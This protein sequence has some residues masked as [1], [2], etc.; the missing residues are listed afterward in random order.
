MFFIFDQLSQMKLRTKKDWGT[1]VLEDLKY[2]GLSD[3]EQIRK[4]KKVSFMKLVRT[5]IKSDTFEKLEKIKSSHSKV[6]HL[7]HKSLKMQTYLQP[8]LTKITNEEAQLIFK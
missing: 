5:R 2:L 1:K 4:M 6:R 8:N 7:E 3:I